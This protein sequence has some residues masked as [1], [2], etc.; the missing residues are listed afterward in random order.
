MNLPVSLPRQLERDGSAFKNIDFRKNGKKMTLKYRM[1]LVIQSW[2][3][4]HGHA[5]PGAGGSSRM[6]GILIWERGRERVF[7][8]EHLSTSSRQVRSF[9]SLVVKRRS[10]VSGTPG[11]LGFTHLAFFTMKGTSEHCTEVVSKQSRPINSVL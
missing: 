3:M 7:K 5:M 10:K 8:F 2:E 1:L 4:R 6:W 9:C 11:K